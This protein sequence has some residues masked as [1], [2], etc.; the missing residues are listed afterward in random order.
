MNKNIVLV[1]YLF[2]I[3]TAN[4]GDECNKLLPNY[5]PLVIT[6]L[7]NLFKQTYDDIITNADPNINP[8][9][10]LAIDDNASSIINVNTNE[11]L[12]LLLMLGMLFDKQTYSGKTSNNNNNNKNGGSTRNGNNDKN[13]TQRKTKHNKKWKTRTNNKSKNTNINKNKNKRITRKYKQSKS[14]RYSRKK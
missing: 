1:L 14:R 4:L 13:K 12:S 7:F 5:D 10:Q 3:I 2:T 9:K 6:P 11:I 8:G